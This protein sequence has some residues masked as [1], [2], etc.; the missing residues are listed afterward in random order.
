MFLDHPIMTHVV[1]E[2]S[3]EPMLRVTENTGYIKK[4]MEKQR[5]G[6]VIHKNQRRI[7]NTTSSS[8]LGGLRHPWE[9]D[10]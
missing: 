3:E 5:I 6:I 7:E 9:A 1:R 8:R 2:S 10:G 4:R